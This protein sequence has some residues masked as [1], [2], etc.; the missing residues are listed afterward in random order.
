MQGTDDHEDH[1][2]NSWLRKLQ[3]PFIYNKTTKAAAIATKA[4]SARRGGWQPFI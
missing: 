3:D 2:C 1:A 4:K